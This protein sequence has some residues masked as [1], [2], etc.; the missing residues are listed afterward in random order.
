M[1]A[2]TLPSTSSPSTRRFDRTDWWFLFAVATF[3]EVLVFLD[4]NDTFFW[5]NDSGDSAF[6]A[7]QAAQPVLSRAFWATV[8]LYPVLIRLVGVETP[9]HVLQVLLSAGATFWLAYEI[10]RLVRNRWWGYALFIFVVLSSRNGAV[11]LANH[12]VG[13][14]GVAFSV[15]AMVV[16]QALHVSRRP[17]RGSWAVLG[18]LVFLFTFA[19]PSYFSVVLLGVAVLAVLAW[20][21][22]AQRRLFGRLAAAGAGFLLLLVIANS[23]AEIESSNLYNIIPQWVLTDD[24]LLEAFRDAGMPTGP[25][26]MALAGEEQDVDDVKFASGPLADWKAWVDENGGTTYVRFLLTNP[27]WVTR[28]Y[29]AA[30]GDLYTSTLSET[31]TLL[32]QGTA[33]SGEQMSPARSFGN[34]FY[35]DSAVLLLLWVGG[36]AFGLG[37]AARTGIP[38][39]PWIWL[40]V[41]MAASAPVLAVI[42]VFGDSVAVGRHGVGLALQLRWGLLIVTAWLVDEVLARRGGHPPRAGARPDD[43]EAS[44]R[45]PSS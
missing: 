42:V 9:M 4:L 22:P 33:F 8:A 38:L 11:Q 23:G 34:P 24:E 25:E 3:V 43:R 26:V 6:W 1:A 14:E 31:N 28:E 35:P 21:R 15:A 2:R 19:R 12:V 20:R 36:V 27:L 45:L 37:W 7:E 18:V 44:D 29:L 39:P 41:A 17:T 40:G 32:D 13:T 30:Q 10:L 5:F 16:A